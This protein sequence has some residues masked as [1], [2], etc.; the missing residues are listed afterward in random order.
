M[1][2]EIPG[3]LVK[4]ELNYITDALS[5]A[6]FVDGKVSAGEQACE[7]KNNLEVKP[8][9][10]I[11]ELAR[12]VYAG[13]VRSAS[14]NQFALPRKIMVPIFSRYE[15]GMEYGSHS[16]VSMMHIDQPELATRTDL[17][18]TVFLNDPDTYDGGEL[19]IET[20]VG[21]QRFKLPAGHAVVYPCH[22]LHWVA[23][24]TRGARLGAITWVQSF[25]RTDAER[26]IL[27][28]LDSVSAKVA[29]G[30][31]NQPGTQQLFNV[32]HKLMRMWADT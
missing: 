6:E 7:V 22:N 29:A 24:V 20:T 25:V 31:S 11:L 32:Y 26:E 10:S 12:M 28:E 4:D 18:C 5:R 30:R 9:Q 16:D 27:F 8:S 23:P 21:E 1:L 13:L 17:S 19:T 2:I 15:V 14:F 3:I